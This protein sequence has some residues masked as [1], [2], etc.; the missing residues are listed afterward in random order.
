MGINTKETRLAKLR[1][2]EARL[3]AIIR[4]EDPEAAEQEEQVLD[5]DDVTAPDESSELNIELTDDMFKDETAHEDTHSP[6]QSEELASLRKELADEKHRFSRYKGSTDKTI[7]ELRQETSKL[8]ARVAQLNKELAEAK[9]VSSEANDPFDSAFNEDVVDILGEDAVNAI[10]NSL[11]AAQ[12]EVR[13][14]KAQLQNKETEDYEDRA[15]RLSD[16]NVEDF[17]RNL[18]RLVPDLQEMN[19]DEGFN[20]WLRSPGPYGIERLKLLHDAQS[21]F[22]YEKVAQ[23][24]TEYKQLQS[25][26]TKKKSSDS[27]DNY[28]GPKGSQTGETQKQQRASSQ[29]G[30]IRQS[31]INKFNK[32]VAKG[33]YKYDSSV[34]AAM[35]E[36]IFKAMSEGKIILD[37]NPI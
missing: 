5:N 2:E 24:F 7:Y 19:M 32:D 12:D 11:K 9:A 4:G 14:L 36:R 22:D 15:K 6:S 25:E 21:E 1:E 31:E 18:N 8:N 26:K 10:R 28:T 16:S 35:E 13:D 17:M 34:P 3:E 33:K 29:D 27:I 30:Y 37:E 20:D 23:F